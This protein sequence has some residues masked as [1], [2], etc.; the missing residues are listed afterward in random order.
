QI[1]LDF[2]YNVL[3]GLSNELKAKLSA[4]RPFN[5]AQAAI[6]E[7]MTP[8]AIALLL[9]HLRRLPSSAR[10]SAGDLILPK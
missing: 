3:S 7:G 6:V 5:I 1:P 2:N 8:A 10:H 9:V 4:A